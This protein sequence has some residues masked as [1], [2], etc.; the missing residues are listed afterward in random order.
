MRRLFQ[1][2]LYLALVLVINTAQAQLYDFAQDVIDEIGVTDPAAQVALA[3]TMEVAGINNSGWIVGHFEEGNGQYQLFVWSPGD[4]EATEEDTYPGATVYLV[5]SPSS[6]LEVKGISN[7]NTIIYNT[8]DDEGIYTGSYRTWNG[9]TYNPAV[10]YE[11]FQFKAISESWIAAD[12]QVG[13]RMIEQGLNPSIPFTCPE[14]QEFSLNPNWI[15]QHSPE[16]WVRARAFNYEVG[17]PDGGA[18]IAFLGAMLCNLS[19]YAFAIKASPSTGELLYVGGESYGQGSENERYTNAHAFAYSREQGDF[20]QTTEVIG[21]A[22]GRVQAVNAI[23]EITGI[24]FTPSAGDSPNSLRGFRSTVAGCPDIDGQTLSGTNL[25]PDVNVSGNSIN[26]AGL[27]VGT[28]NTGTARGFLYTNTACFDPSP[29]PVL[30]TSAGRRLDP[31]NTDG[32][33][34]DLTYHAAKEVGLSGWLMLGPAVGIN[35][36]NQIVGNRGWDPNSNSRPYLLNPAECEDLPARDGT[37]KGFFTVADESDYKLQN[38]ALTFIDRIDEGDLF[39]LIDDSF[40]DFGGDKLFSTDQINKDGPGGTGWFI[41]EKPGFGPEPDR[42]VLLATNVVPEGESAPPGYDNYATYRLRSEKSIDIPFWVG[43]PG[44]ERTSQCV[45]LFKMW[46]HMES[47]PEDHFSIRIRKEGGTDIDWMEVGTWDHTTVP[48]QWTQIAAPIPDNLIGEKVEFEFVFK[49]DLCETGEGVLIDDI[50]LWYLSQDSMVGLFADFVE[51]ATAD[52]ELAKAIG[53]LDEGEGTSGRQLQTVPVEAPTRIVNSNS[54][55]GL[56]NNILRFNTAPNTVGLTSTTTGTPVTYRIGPV[57]AA[58]IL[59]IGATLL[60]AYLFDPQP[61]ESIIFSAPDEV[62]E[63]DPN[64][65]PW[66]ENKRKAFF[67]GLPYLLSDM[68]E[69]QRT[70]YY[71]FALNGLLELQDAHAKSSYATP[72][73]LQ[74]FS[75]TN[76]KEITIV[77]PTEIGTA[78]SIHHHRMMFKRMFSELALTTKQIDV[79]VYVYNTATQEYYEVT[80][81]N[82]DYYNAYEQSVRALQWAS[83]IQGRLLIDDS[84]RKKDETPSIDIAFYSEFNDF[85][86]G[87]TGTPNKPNIVPK[88][89]PTPLAALAPEGVA[90]EVETAQDI[91]VCGEYVIALGRRGQMA[92]SG[93]PNSSPGTSNTIGTISPPTKSSDFLDPVQRAANINL[94]VIDGFDSNDGN[95]TNF[96]VYAGQSQDIIIE[97][98]LADYYLDGTPFELVL[99]DGYLYDWG[100]YSRAIATEDL[101]AMGIKP[102]NKEMDIEDF[103]PDEPGI[104][105]MI[106]NIFFEQDELQDDAEAPAFRM[107]PQDGKYELEVCVYREE[108]EEF[109]LV[110]QYNHIISHALHR[111]ELDGSQKVMAPWQDSPIELSPDNVAIFIP[112][113]KEASYLLPGPND[114][115]KI[116]VFGYED[117]NYNLKE[118]AAPEEILNFHPKWQVNPSRKWTTYALQSPAFL[119]PG[120]AEPKDGL[121]GPTQKYEKLFDRFFNHNIDGAAWFDTDKGLNQ[122]LASVEVEYDP[123][124][125]PPSNEMGASSTDK[126]LLASLIDNMNTI[127][128][129]GNPIDKTLAIYGENISATR[130]LLAVYQ[131]FLLFSGNPV[132]DF[133]DLR[134]VIGLLD[135]VWPLTPTDVGADEGAVKLMDQTLF[136]AVE[137]FANYENVTIFVMHS[138]QPIL[139]QELYPSAFNRDNSWLQNTLEYDMSALEK[140]RDNHPNMLLKFIHALGPDSFVDLAHCTTNVPGNVQTD[141]LGK[142]GLAGVLGKT[143]FSTLNEN[144]GIDQPLS[145]Y[146][147]ANCDLHR[148]YFQLTLREGAS[149]ILV[150]TR[151]SYKLKAHDFMGT[152]PLFPVGN[153]FKFIYENDEERLKRFVIEIENISSGV[154]DLLDDIITTDGN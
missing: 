93:S 70:T 1:I 41:N 119:E 97:S 36:N 21:G 51:Q 50:R 114:I 87:E 108:T 11:F 40:E 27:V 67:N 73:H 10:S 82:G 55:P 42:Q 14:F 101:I 28:Y 23:G 132:Q 146:M 20:F 56:A 31:F 100:V 43:I 79:T 118:L 133:R 150:K 88:S 112:G 129:P 66:L 37:R 104:H 38:D 131:T 130:A 6:S 34:K 78:H 149:P 44:S 4:E 117:L 121:Y 22:P 65:K 139:Q 92:R 137:F 125:E 54:V 61:V 135:P 153:I 15:I 72:Q 5:G 59:Y 151:E 62:Y 116:D 136:E 102:K 3:A 147:G 109:I 124:E 154:N 152:S 2:E 63:L 33:M 53:L 80:A 95:I 32:S 17:T 91:D 75:N 134:V 58:S 19:S 126:Q 123:G 106:E 145:G 138:Q 111:M 71:A 49:T 30:E 128:A 64:L 48:D 86:N 103:F 127:A 141:E 90:T 7:N 29:V 35:D 24:W 110:Q 16:N 26:D 81:H 57:G 83:N 84:E 13:P 115:G 18:Q 25:I 107:L 143:C 148:N 120:P 8:R 46:S 94:N 60:H 9:L 96:D 12:E 89:P 122:S 99:A 85:F 140:Y 77:I 98:P 144:V 52:G 76:S 47:N 68:T 74:S 69:E 105:V 39:N 45:L 113:Y 142:T